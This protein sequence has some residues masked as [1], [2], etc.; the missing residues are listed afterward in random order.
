MWSYRYSCQILIIIE[1]SQQILKIISSFRENPASGS[2]VVPCG[3]IDGRT[4]MTKQIVAFHNFANAHKNGHCLNYDSAK[5][6]YFAVD[7][8]S[9]S[10]ACGPATVCYPVRAPFINR[11]QYGNLTLKPTTNLLPETCNYMPSWRSR[12]HSK[13]D[14]VEPLNSFTVLSKGVLSRIPACTEVTAHA[15]W[16]D[17]GG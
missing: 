15:S 14:T 7:A 17:C 8:R 12:R 11:A 1:F 6:I 13:P 5:W 4:D 9:C 3:R 10:Y 16:F 2:R